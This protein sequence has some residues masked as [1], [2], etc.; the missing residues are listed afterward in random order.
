MIILIQS[1]LLSNLL[2]IFNPPF[3]S[4][5]GFLTSSAFITVM[6]KS[7]VSKVYAANANGYLLN[8]F[9]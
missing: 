7:H 3:F 8:I 4:P 6:L 9:S 2:F 5:A 1:F